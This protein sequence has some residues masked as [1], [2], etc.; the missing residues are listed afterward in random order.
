MRKLSHL[1]ENECIICD[2]Q[3]KFNSTISSIKGHCLESMMW[4][5][6]GSNTV[7]YPSDHWESGNDK[8]VGSYGSVDAANERQDKVYSFEEI[9]L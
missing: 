9:E 4:E 2:T 7:V 5:F 8:F 1:K 3:E 6:F